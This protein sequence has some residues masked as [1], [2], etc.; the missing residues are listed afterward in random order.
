[1]VKR[2]GAPRQEMIGKGR[3]RIPPAD[4]EKY[5]REDHPLYSSARLW[6]DGNIDPAHSREVLA[7]SLREDYGY[8]P[9]DF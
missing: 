1:M 8:D 3:G 6:D 4:L 7:L 5:E 9:S 2:E